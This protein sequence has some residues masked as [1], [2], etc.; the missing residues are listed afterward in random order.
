MTEQETQRNSAG[1]IGIRLQ[2]EH[3]QRLLDVRDLYGLTISE[4]IRFCIDF[5]FENHDRA[6]PV[7]PKDVELLKKLVAS[8]RFESE[9]E[10]HQ[11]LFH[12]GLR[13]YVHNVL[14]EEQQLD[15]LLETEI[16]QREKQEKNQKIAR[17]LR[18]R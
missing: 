4:A 2:D 5:T 15:E 13:A 1:F 16:E 11:E 17:K 10:A 3:M 9:A 14:V 6:F 8:G 18:T 7:P 12:M